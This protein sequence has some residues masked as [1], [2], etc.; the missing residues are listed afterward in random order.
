MKEKSYLI[1]DDCKFG[2][3][4]LVFQLFIIPLL[5]LLL[6]MIDLAYNPTLNDDTTLNESSMPQQSQLSLHF[7]ATRSIPCL[8]KIYPVPNPDRSSPPFPV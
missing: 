7:P 5:V 2:D 4:G 1:S 8:S 3:G 6:Y